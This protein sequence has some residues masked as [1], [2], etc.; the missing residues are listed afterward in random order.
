MNEFR[1]EE[2]KSDLIRVFKILL[3]RKGLIILGT[4]LVTLLVAV[5]TL[6]LPKVYRSRAVIA[7]SSIRRADQDELSTAMEIPIYRSYTNIFHSHGLFRTFVKRQGGKEAWDL[8]EEFFETR[9]KPVYAFEYGKPR[10]KARDNS[11][12]GVEITGLGDSAEAARNKTRLMGAYIITTLLNMQ[13]GN[14][15]ETIGTRSES[16]IAKLEKAI[17]KLKIETR[18]LKE[19]ESLIEDQLLKLPGFGTR[20]GRELV[21]A[22]ENTAKYLSPQQQLVAVKMSIK[23]NQ[24]QTKQ[25]LRNIKINRLLLGYLDKTAYLFKSNTEYLANDGLLSALREE[26]ERFFAGKDDEESKLA[27]YILSEQFF[28]FR[29][30]QST[31]YKFISGPTLPERHFKPK[32]KRIVIAAFFLA[33]FILVFIAFLVE[34]WENNKKTPANETLSAAQPKK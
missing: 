33:F 28:Y 24:I 13:V 17:L 18:D 6:L 29:K 32:R 21:N 31:I 2:N 23:D 20:T 30:L 1:S 16:G 9:F 22:N 26:K 5:I 34:A 19:K 12:I 3:K 4:G 14:F 11:I 25:N 8:D 10:G 27:S 15:F 7:F